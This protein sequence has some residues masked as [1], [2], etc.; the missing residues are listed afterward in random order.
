MARYV[1]G[2]KKRSHDK[3]QQ[4]LEAAGEVFAERGFKAATIQEISQRANANI[5]S[6]YYHFRD[7]ESLYR[8]GSPLRAGTVAG[9]LPLLPDG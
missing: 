1:E 2:R 5:A 9:A 8:E 4:F 6:A 3:S 7:K